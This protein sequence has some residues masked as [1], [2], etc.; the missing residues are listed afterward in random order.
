MAFYNR[1]LVVIGTTLVAV[2]YSNLVPL[3]KAV[4]LVV[5]GVL[6][7]SVNVWV[8]FFSWKRPEYLLYGAE[9]HFEKWKFER[10][11][12]TS[13]KSL[14]SGGPEQFHEGLVRD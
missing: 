10:K 12:S 4:A 8:S 3:H 9:T 6:L 11:E 1:T 14:T 2:L 13:G 5:G 7:V